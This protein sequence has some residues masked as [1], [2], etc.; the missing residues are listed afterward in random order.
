[1]YGV[2][3]GVSIMK[4]LRPFFKKNVLKSIDEE[5]FLFLNTFFICLFVVCYFFYNFTRKKK[6]IDF[7][8]YK[9]LNTTEIVSM[10]GVSLFTVI[11]TILVLQLD[12]GEQTPF[13]T[14]MLTKGFSTIFV[15]AIGMIVYKENYSKLQIMGIGLILLGIYFISNK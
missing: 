4:S 11:S 10:M 2:L 7:S 12:K 13:I 6:K 5:D 8:K 14:S 15:I 9:N 3:F 1:M